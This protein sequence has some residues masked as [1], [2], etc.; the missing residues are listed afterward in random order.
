MSKQP[1]ENLESNSHF[2]KFII[3]STSKMAK[4]TFIFESIDENGV[5]KLSNFGG[6]EELS[7]IAKRWGHKNWQSK[8]QAVENYKPNSYE[9]V[10]K[11]VLNF[12]DAYLYKLKN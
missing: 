8:K 4:E 3:A 12:K 10:K 1:K 2:P 11:E 6:L 5:A 9:L 7:G